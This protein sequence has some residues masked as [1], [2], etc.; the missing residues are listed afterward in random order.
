ML[1]A[2]P[3]LRTHRYVHTGYVVLHALRS[4]CRD[5]NVQSATYGAVAL[6]W[7]CLVGYVR[8]VPIATY[9]SVALR[10]MRCVRYVEIDIYRSQRTHRLRCLRCIRYVAL[11]VF[12]WLRSLR[13]L[14]TDRNV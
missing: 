10:C 3:S 1:V 2:L 9:T 4:L 12:G 13:W 14:H 5:R 6:R 8:C 11:G 7:L